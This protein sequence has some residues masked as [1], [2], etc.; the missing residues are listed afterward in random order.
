MFS[1]RSP[2]QLD[3]HYY[4]TG[5]SDFTK[6]Y[7]KC[8]ECQQDNTGQHWCRTCNGKRFQ[9]DFDKWTT[10]DPEID[11]F[12]QQIQLSATSCEGVIEWIPF[13]RFDDFIFISEGECSAIEKATWSDGYLEFWNHEKNY[14]Q[15]FNNQSVCFKRLDTLNKRELLKEIKYQ[16]RFRGGWAIAVYGITK[17]PME[18]EYMI[19]LQHAKHGS[20]RN[21]LDNNFKE[22]T[23]K[24]K[25]QI[26][27][28]IAY[29]LAKIHET[30]LM[31]RDFHSG[32]IVNETIT[33]SYITGFGSCKPV[34]LNYEE[35]IH[36]IIPYM[37][38]ETLNR[39]EYTQASDVYSFG[40]IMSEVFTS[41]PPYYN[42]PHDEKLVKLICDGKKTEIKCEIPQLLRDIMEKCWDIDPFVRPT[43]REL[44]IQFKNYSTNNDSELENQ[45]EEANE[46][47][48]NFI[49]YDPKM[50]YPQD[51][52]HMQKQWDLR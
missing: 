12:I 35:K 11:E 16:L 52:I 36:G 23:W 25:I 38:P 8:K 20:L 31:H 42:L 5:M 14:W 51:Y 48:K 41:Y 40:M 33:S 15:R 32:N 1:N 2:F 34:T 28:F 49:H 9:S 18:N 30:G 50:T 21:M 26:I 44:E 22:L 7:G 47:N 6:E 29:G 13:D 19:V 37:A 46:S 24:Q 27:L 43:A 10:G 45:I 39:G 17:S 3:A 4:I